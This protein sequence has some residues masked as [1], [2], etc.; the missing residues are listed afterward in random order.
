M[1]LYDMKRSKFVTTTN[2]MSVGLHV[3]MLMKIIYFF[4]AYIQKI[5]GWGS[6]T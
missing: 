6:P 4:V 3:R 5:R 2:N 1:K